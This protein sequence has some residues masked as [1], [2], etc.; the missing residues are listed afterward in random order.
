M[1]ETVHL[2]VY[3]TMA[4]WEP[5][6]AIS[7]INAATWQRDPG[8]YQVRTVGTTVAPVV[9]MG[10]VRIVPDLTADEVQAGDSAMLILSGASN[11]DSGGNPEMAA[12]ARDFLDAGV[13]VAAICGATYGLAVARLLDDRAHTS[14]A[15]EYLAMSG[16]RGGHLYRD[17]P[18]TNDRGLI[19]A[20]AV[21][22]VDFG[23]AIF[24]QLDLFTDEVLD[25]WLRLYRD[26]DA[27]AFPVLA[28]AERGNSPVDVA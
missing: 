26:G 4:D 15:A 9:T 18:V 13:P 11:W 17:E 25:A 6:Y 5:G 21:H 22:A 19:T 10:G 20:G 7:Q 23:G 24:A 2:A 8:R 14:N 28:A 3:D 27:S 16:Y 12:K 1:T